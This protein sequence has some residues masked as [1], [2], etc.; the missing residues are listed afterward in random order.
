[1]FVLKIKHTF[2]F[3]LFVVLGFKNMF[4]YFILLLSIKNLNIL[5]TANLQLLIVKS[6]N[7]INYTF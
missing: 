7:I 1:M 4:K 5:L 6:R 3:L 2:F